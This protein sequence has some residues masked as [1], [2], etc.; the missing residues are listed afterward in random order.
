MHI[1]HLSLFATAFFGIKNVI[2]LRLPCEAY[3][4]N[5]EMC[6]RGLCLAYVYTLLK[7]RKNHPYNNSHHYSLSAC[8]HRSRLYTC[9]LCR[10]FR[11]RKQFHSAADGYI[12]ILD[13]IH[14]SCMGCC[15]HN[16]SDDRYRHHSCIYPE[17]CRHYGRY[18]EP[19]SQAYEYIR[20]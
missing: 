4:I 5:L 14:P 2:I 12:R 7:G 11:H 18:R 8:C 15:R 16:L 10:H 17:L 3:V 6:K 20:S 9:H 19:R 13:R 1:F